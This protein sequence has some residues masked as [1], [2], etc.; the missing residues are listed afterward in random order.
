MSDCTTSSGV[1]SILEKINRLTELFDPWLMPI[2]MIQFYAQNIGYDVGLNRNEFPIIDNA[3]P[4]LQQIEANKYL[5]FMTSQLPEWYKVKTS[6][7][8][9]RVMLYS[10]GLVGDVVYYYTKSYYDGSTTSNDQKFKNDIDTSVYK[11]FRDMYNAMC[12]YQLTLDDLQDVVKNDWLL[13]NWNPESLSEDVTQ[14]PDD[15]FPTPHFRLWFDLFESLES[16]HFSSDLV[17]HESMAVAINAIRPLNTV[18]EGVSSY[19]KILTDVYLQ[20]KVR[21]RKHINLIS[22][23][24]ADYWYEAP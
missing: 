22:D 11:N 2:D 19:F 13:T 9:L 6:R 20:P 8:S 24:P 1:I 10:F 17:K 12:A 21:L 4:M 14:I 23:T 5:R 7:P 3:D 16:L 15:Y 18:F